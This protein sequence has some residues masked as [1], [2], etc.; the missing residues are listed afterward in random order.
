[1][2][3]LS[4]GFLF[5]ARA[6]SDEIDDSI[7]RSTVLRVLWVDIDGGCPV[8]EEAVKAEARRILGTAGIQVDW[9][10]GSISSVSSG[11]V[12]RVTLLSKDIARRRHPPM[13]DTFSRGSSNVSVLV[14]RGG[15]DPDDGRTP[16]GWAR[17]EPCRR[18]GGRPRA[19]SRGGPQHSPRLRR[20][21]G[22]SSERIDTHPAAR[23][24]RSGHPSRAAAAL[25]RPPVD[26]TPGGRVS[27]QRQALIGEDRHWPTPAQK[28][29]ENSQEDLRIRQ[30]LASARSR[31]SL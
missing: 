19:G 27:G 8:R 10:S 23:L 28:P 9:Q 6:L 25:Q 21:H 15:P 4:L 2:G 12:V 16:M 20:P 29:P 3:S 1:M 31:A 30:G 22:L 5:L 13:G 11:E 18:S 14:S 26:S 7:P 17:P 24:A